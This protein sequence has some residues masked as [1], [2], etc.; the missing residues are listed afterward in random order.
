M[1]VS[2]LAKLSGV[3][4][5]HLSQVLS[6]KRN[7]RLT[8][9]RVAQFLTGEEIL[10]MGWTEEAAF[11]RE[12]ASRMAARPSPETTEGESFGFKSPRPDKR[13]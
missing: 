13:V 2:R 11:G 5:S 9:W 1:T 6:G 12:L 3:G 7:G 4:R 10:L 8:A